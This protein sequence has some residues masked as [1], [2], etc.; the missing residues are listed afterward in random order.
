ME[1]PPERKIGAAGRKERGKGKWPT[2]QDR[3]NQLAVQGLRARFHDLDPISR[4][5]YGPAASKRRI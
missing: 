3:K 5:P 4:T 1:K 2:G